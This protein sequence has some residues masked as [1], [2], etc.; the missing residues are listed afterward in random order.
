MSN[1]DFP[2]LQ[3]RPCEVGRLNSYPNSSI[4]YYCGY[5]KICLDKKKVT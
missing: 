5:Y 3:E 1:R 2:D 4:Y